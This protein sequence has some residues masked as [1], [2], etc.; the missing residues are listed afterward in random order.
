[1]NE[2][3]NKRLG[4]FLAAYIFFNKV[5]SVP[6]Y[7]ANERARRMKCPDNLIQANQFSKGDNNEE[8]VLGFSDA[9]GS[10]VCANNLGGD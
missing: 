1:M 6:E 5:R 8:M 2:K 4:V 9:R 3:I 10:T 7:L